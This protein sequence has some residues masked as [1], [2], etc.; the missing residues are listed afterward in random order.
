MAPQGIT[1]TLVFQSQAELDEL[2]T[3]INAARDFHAPPM[4]DSQRSR[5]GSL[6]DALRV[7]NAPA[8]AGHPD[9]PAEDPNTADMSVTVTWPLRRGEMQ[10]VVF[11][12][13]GGP[14]PETLTGYDRVIMRAM[15]EQALGTLTP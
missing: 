1:R 12:R 3:A 5:L 10:T 9:A 15:L 7:G 4:S 11:D 14:D 8:G 13:D 2:L 6:A